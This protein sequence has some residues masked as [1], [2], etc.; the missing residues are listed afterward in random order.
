MKVRSKLLALLLSLVMAFSL[1]VPAV[2][3][4]AG[5]DP[6]AEDGKIVILHTNDVHCGIDQEKKDDKVTKIGYA[7]L[8][9]YKTEMEA[10]YGADNVTLVDAGDAIQGETIGN[11]TDGEYIVKIMNEIGYDLAIPGNH[12]FDFQVPN[13]LDLASKTAEYDYLCCNFMDLTTNQSAFDGYKVVSYGDVKVGYVGISTPETFTS[14]TPTY[15]Q[16][17][18]GN[19]IYSFS[20]GNDGKNLYTAVQNAVDAAKKDGADYVVAVA[21][22]G[23]ET[24]DSPYSSTSVIANTTGIDV[25]IDGHSH[26]VVSGDTK[27]N[28]DGKDVI[29]NQTGTKLANIGK[30]IIDTE[31][32]DIAAELV[33]GYDEQDETIL[34]FIQGM[35][36]EFEE[37]LS[38]PIGKTE[39]ALTGS[40]ATDDTPRLV[41]SQETNAGDL[42][43]DA[44]RIMMETDVAFMNGG[45]IR[46]DIPAGDLTYGDIVNILPFS[47]SVCTMEVT[48][49]NILDALE[50][51]A[52]D[53]PKENG[54]FL[55]VSGLSYT[56]DTTIPSPVTANDHGE[57]AGVDG[58]R[59]V[60][61]VKVGDEAIDPAKTYT[62]AGHN[63]MLKNCGDGFTMFSD[64]KLIK[65][66]V[67]MQSQALIDYIKGELDGTVPASYAEPAGRITLKLAEVE[68]EPEPEP[69][70]Q[71]EPEPTPE[72]E[73]QPE[74]TYTVVR[75]DNLSKIAKSQYGDSSKWRVIYEANKGVIKNPNMI[76]PGQTLVIPAA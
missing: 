37:L 67:M 73:P 14:S 9:A 70:P 53:A 30:I 62:L 44:F 74:G 66:E 57:Y 18:D 49:Q 10:Q 61:D 52:K 46:A 3:A 47:N 38:E 64:G 20:E 75:G 23:I 28:K 51:G 58:E 12:E 69:E 2:A 65:D 45:G 26:S 34:T 8:A 50:W 56:I 36:D 71:P 35:K 16:D 11:L 25:L 68:P 29:V 41:R 76:W 15:F 4:P 32:G 19:Y 13:F 55:Q 59:R 22:L 6:A 39:A 17:G 54:G 1:A 72:P 48:G 24:P 21:H 63:Y 43:A 60:K 33:S 40:V 27:P 42:V 31:T 7:G 5:D